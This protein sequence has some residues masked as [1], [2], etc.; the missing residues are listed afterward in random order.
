MCTALIGECT[1]FHNNNGIILKFG[2]PVNVYV[3]IFTLLRTPH[4]PNSL[5]GVFSHLPTFKMLF[6][7]KSALLS[8]VFLPVGDK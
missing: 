7:V 4:H 6:F 8:V 5:N 1:R 2:P 3:P